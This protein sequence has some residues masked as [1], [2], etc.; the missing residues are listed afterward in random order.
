[1]TNRNRVRLS[2][3]SLGLALALAAAPAFAQNTTSG[4]GGR[5]TSGDGAPLAGTQVTITHVA[6][7]STSTATT[8]SEGRYAARGLRVGGPYTVTFTKDGKTETR[9]G[10]YLPLAT[11]ATV[12][13]RIGE[14]T[15]TTLATVEVTGVLTTSEVFS[16][17]NMGAGTAIARDQLE[18]FASIQ[19]NL[20]DYAR[21][22]PRL[23]QTDKERGEI[24]A[25][26]QNTRFNSITIDGV[27]TND[28]FGLESNNLPTAKQPISIDT[29]ESV[30]V[31][32]S[33][34]GVTQRGY[35][36]ANINAVTKS[37]TNE[38]KGRASYVYRENGWVR[39]NE[40]GAR[41]PGFEDEETKGLT[42]G[43]PL[44]KDKLFFFLAYEEFKV[45]SAAPDFGPLGS[46]ASNIVGIAPADIAT[47][48]GYAARNCGTVLPGQP[49]GFD[50]GST[51]ATGFGTSVE[52]LLFKLDWNIN[53]QHRASLRYNKTDQS[54]LVLPNF[55]SSTLSLSSHWYTQDKVFESYVGQLFS[56]WTDTFSTEFKLSY[57][58]Y[59]SVPKPT[60][61]LP[62]IR[63]DFGGN[64]LRA[65]TEQFRHANE[66]ATETVNAYLAGNWFRGD[67][68]FKFGVDFESN[69]VYNYFLESNFGDYRFTSLNNFRDGIYNTYVFRTCVGGPTCNPRDAAV[70]WTLKNTGYLFQDT[71]AVNYNL[72]LQYGFR[73]DVAGL[74]DEP[75]YNAQAHAAFGYDNRQTIDGKSL[76]QPR[77]GFNY[78]FDAE[79]PTQLRGG[80][81]LFEGAAANVWLSNP[82]TNS[83]KTIQIFGCGTAI[84]FT[85]NCAV[86]GP[87]TFFSSDPNNQ[88]RFGTPRA[89]VDLIDPGLRQ[90]SVWKANLAF[91]H[92]LPWWGMVASAEYIHTD[93]KAGI[94]YE[95]LNLGN[96]TMSGALDGR[97]LFWRTSAPNTLTGAYNQGNGSF[98]GT[99]RWLSNQAFREVLLAKSTGKGGGESLTLGLHR[100][101]QN[102]WAWS[103]AYTYTDATEV[104]PLTSSRAISNWNSRM[105]FNPN[106]EVASPSNYL[107]RDRVVGTFDY[108]HHF[109]EGY[110]TQFTVFYEG[111][112]GKP[113]SWTFANDMN[114]D[115]ISG[116][117]LLYV[118]AGPGDVLFRGGT[119]GTTVITPAQ[120]EAEFWAYVNANPY[121]AGLMG[122]VAGRNAV[123]SGW[124][125]TFD[126]RVSQELP[127]F[128]EGHKSTLTFDI[129]NFGNLLNKD[130]GRI[131]EYGFP[132]RAQFVN[133][134]GID[135]ATGKYIYAL[136]RNSAT[137]AFTPLD[138]ASLRDARGESRWA[139]QVTLRYDF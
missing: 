75:I 16:T 46:G 83:G 94:F 124:V 13:V 80:F 137:G 35:T 77:V 128:A 115:G 17:T 63:I 29:I 99:A 1:M 65:G 57:R 103:L 120:E 60:A 100:P 33:N 67:H 134:A 10:V 93:V 69:N 50:L 15:A 126:V 68:E 45:S 108:R 3:L 118:P 54:Q 74:D 102:N 79:R 55:N 91:E 41:F 31:N 78:T 71:W 5:V 111:R 86:P 73:Y 72:T 81:G 98:G 122:Q 121:L 11:V 101:L 136:R 18:G 114:G 58:D 59:F 61:Q 127:G 132:L 135:P 12:D 30:Q 22:D 87:G 119:F 19:R 24:S 88:P 39:K 23:A 14:P 82:F 66:L 7:G 89:D 116:N 6:S 32:I 21:L 28:T 48:I 96:P 113:Y 40:N 131:E 56:D 20:Q 85:A 76:F 26:G 36:G 43:G 51:G 44:V 104:S 37:G 112:A 52:D 70:D 106:E 129:L 125:N 139:V 117:D 138:Q 53:D 47:A 2:Q 92:E 4:I 107:V 97:Q 9:E 64:S 123:R 133:F 27:T 8:D 38:F 95:H 62:Q 130:W 34:Y 25:G 109:F 110:K 105:I 49:C 90:P 84:G 42:L